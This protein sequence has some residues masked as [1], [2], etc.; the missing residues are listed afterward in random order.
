[1]N[2]SNITLRQWEGPDEI[3]VRW[4]GTN[5]DISDD[6]AWDVSL[7]SVDVNMEGVTWMALRGNSGLTVT[8]LKS[9]T[10][11]PTVR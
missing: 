8:Y 1:M 7:E 11:T 6:S 5:F 10:V 4:N 3:R 9:I 2:I